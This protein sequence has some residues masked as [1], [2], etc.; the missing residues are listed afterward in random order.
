[1]AVSSRSVKSNRGTKNTTRSHGMQFPL[2]EKTS[3]DP[4]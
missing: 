3:W 4:W 2:V 1:M